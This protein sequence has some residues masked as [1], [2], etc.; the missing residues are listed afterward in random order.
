MDQND[1]AEADVNP[2]ALSV[3]NREA[4]YAIVDAFND[5]QNAVTPEPNEGRADEL[6]EV[7][8]S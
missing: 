4:F 3:S 2:I 6:D 1:S 5:W 7:S 8:T